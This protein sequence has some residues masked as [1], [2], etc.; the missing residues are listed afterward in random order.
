MEKRI[1]KHI[2]PI[3][4][5]WKI[6]IIQFIGWILS[7]IRD[8]YA[9]KILE[10]LGNTYG[11]KLMEAIFQFIPKGASGWALLIFA[12]TIFI[13]V[14]YELNEGRK[15]KPLT[16]NNKPIKLI[17]EKKD[18]VYQMGVDV[19]KFG[20]QFNSISVGSFDDMMDQF[21]IARKTLN[22]ILDKRLPESNML[23]NNYVEIQEKIKKL[24][25]MANSYEYKLGEWATGMESIAGSSQEHKDNID[26]LT[27]EIWGND[28]ESIRSQ[29]NSLTKQL[30]EL[31]RREREAD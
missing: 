9:T 26:R 2:I 21:V 6:W 13:V 1:R 11:G 23:F 28:K 7:L 19:Q 27:N 4:K 29:I 12:L 16:K 24:N 3:F 18:L 20:N 22:K 10:Q 14:I 25:A 30:V 15:I 5:R 31:L 8:Y 17:P